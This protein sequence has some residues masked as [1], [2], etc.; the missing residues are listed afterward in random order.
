MPHRLIH[1]R[2]G[3]SQVPEA[4]V[5]AFLETRYQVGEEGGFSLTIGAH[6]EDLARAHEARR[7]SCS[8]LITSDNPA[9]TQVSPEENAAARQALLL[10]L[11]NRNL[12]WCEG[13]GVHPSGDWPSEK[14]VMVWGLGRDGAA[15]LGAKFGQDAVV[16]SDADAV[17]RLLLIRK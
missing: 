10:E 12:S 3:Q 15:D 8:V 6:S 14:S 2:A 9:S 17:P 4:L 16:W 13:E 1:P 11:K 5:K 7:V